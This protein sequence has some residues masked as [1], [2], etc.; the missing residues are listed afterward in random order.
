MVSYVKYAQR[1]K[2]LLQEYKKLISQ[3]IELN[4]KISNIRNE[5][6]GWDNALLKCA[7]N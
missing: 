2:I 4:K 6:N 7:K 1:R 5:M 3:R